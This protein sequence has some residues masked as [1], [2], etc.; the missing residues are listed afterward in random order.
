MLATLQ[1]ITKELDELLSELDP[2]ALHASDAVKLLEES[3][4][5]EKRA[6]AIRTLVADRAADSSDWT[7]NGHRSPEEWLAAKTG[8]SFGQ[9]RS[10]LETSAKLEELPKTSDELRRGRLSATQLNEIGPAATPEN[11]E[12]LLGAAKKES[13]KGLKG[14]CAKEKAKARSVDDEAARHARIHKERHHR[15]WTDAEGGYCY[16]GR[17]TAM[18]GA[19]FDAALAAETEKVFKAA[20]AEGRRESSEAYRADALLNLITSGGANVDSTVVIRVDD[21]ALRDGEGTA[22]TPTGPIPVREAIGAI[23]AGAFVKVL[24][25]N[26]VDVSRWPIRVVTGRRRSIPPSS[27]VTAIA[28]C[29]RGAHRPIACRC[30]TTASTTARRGQ[31]PTGTWPRCVPSTTTSSPTAVTAS[32]VGPV[33]GRGAVRRSQGAGTPPLVT[34]TGRGAILGDGTRRV[35]RDDRPVPLA[36]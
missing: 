31:P 26:G 13:F 9:A 36:V 35:C 32:R 33:R 20:H 19:R 23:L 8:T 34:P 14:T 25:T 30:T 2:S 28:V 3:T 18:A 27:S 15:S 1:S 4:A 6:V 10:T 7:R 12:R 17:N 5:I 24:A 16:S 21:S 22:E 29:V 11:E